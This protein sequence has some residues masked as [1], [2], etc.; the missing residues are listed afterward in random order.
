MVDGVP[1]WLRMRCL[2]APKTG[3]S[4]LTLEDCVAYSERRGRA[5]V[6]DGAGSSYRARDFARVLAEHWRD[7][8]PAGD[9]LT[10]TWVASIADVWRAAAPTDGVPWWATP[11]QTRGRHGAATI[12]TIQIN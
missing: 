10:K 7:K 4:L 12:V 9:S 6:T 1:W 11:E 5:V 8:P 3:E 2:V